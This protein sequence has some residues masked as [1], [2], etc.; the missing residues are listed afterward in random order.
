M[1]SFCSNWSQVRPCCCWI[2]EGLRWPPNYGWNEMGWR[3]SGP[4]GGP[5]GGGQQ[6]E[7]GL[8]RKGIKV[9]LQW[10]QITELWE[11]YII[12]RG[13]VCGLWRAA[14]EIGH[15]VVSVAAIG[16]VCP[17]YWVAVRLGPWAVAG[18]ELGEGALVWPE[19]QLFNWVNWRS[20]ATERYS[21]SI[22][23]VRPHSARRRRWSTV[24]PSCPWVVEEPAFQ[25]QRLC[26]MACKR[27]HPMVEVP[28]R[29]SECLSVLGRT[30]SKLPV[31]GLSFELDWVFPL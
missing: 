30:D 12:P 9:D 25:G 1:F 24:S 31:E 13:P 21:S 8:G 11:R 27:V 28:H 10:G 22:R 4:A 29:P 18:S 19:Q 16:A 14:E 5:R 15:R 23:K 2:A 20:G 26:W 7:R 3:V 17:S 6:Q